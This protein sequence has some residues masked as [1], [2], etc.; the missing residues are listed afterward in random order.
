MDTFE[1]LNRVSTTLN[2]FCRFFEI[3][4]IN[5][6]FLYVEIWLILIIILWS[7]IVSRFKI[8]VL[9]QIY[10]IRETIGSNAISIT[11]TL[12][13]VPAIQLLS[14]ID[15]MLLFFC[16]KGERFPFLILFILISLCFTF[17]LHMILYPARQV[18]CIVMVSVRLININLNIA[19]LSRFRM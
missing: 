12:S 17:I 4:L 5:I 18:L 10:F 1:N 9:G 13:R 7:I 3:F 15:Q 2:P 6:W 16:Y 19:D 11:H 14:Q 8:S